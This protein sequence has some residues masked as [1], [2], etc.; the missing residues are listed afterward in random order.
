MNSAGFSLGVVFSGNL[1]IW[2]VGCTKFDSIVLLYSVLLEH[3]GSI[4]LF[5]PKHMDDVISNSGVSSG[6]NA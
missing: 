1:F 4:L 2:T 3:E 5:F 6:C